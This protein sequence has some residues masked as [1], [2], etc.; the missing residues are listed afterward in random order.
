MMELI[1]STLAVALLTLFTVGAGAAVGYL[2]K[3]MWRG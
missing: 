1:V 3:E 2:I